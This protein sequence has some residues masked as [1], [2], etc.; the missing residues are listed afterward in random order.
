VLAATLRE[1]ARIGYGAL[2]IEDVARLADV[3]KTT[4]YRRWPTKA[5][6]VR[7][8]IG[9]FGDDRACTPDTGSLRS[10]LLALAR[11]MIEFIESPQGKSVI[12]LLFAEG[13]EP[14]LAAFA[15]SFR[16]EHEAVPRAVIDRAIARGELPRGTDAFLLVE[17]LFGAIAHRMLLAHQRVDAVLL[18]RLVDLLLSGATA[19]GA[20][21][22]RRAR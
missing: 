4:V 3:N 14:E 7:A 2:S 10:D 12:R 22:L 21:R 19:G 17:T 16:R 8:A 20:R 1:L 18:E 9:R 5:D 15:S 11:S 13:M 6:L